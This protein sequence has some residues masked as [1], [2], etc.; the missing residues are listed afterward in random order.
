MT[1]HS[2]SKKAVYA[3]L[4]GNLLIVVTKF[5]AA[6][7]TGSSAM[8][9]EGIHSLVD[10][11]NEVLLLYGIRRASRPADYTHP[12]GH[13]R[14]IYFWSFVVAVLI[15]ALGAGVSLYEGVNHILRPEPIRNVTISYVVLGASALFEAASWLVAL[16]IFRREKG[17]L[18]YFAAI[19]QSKDPTTFTVLFEDSAALLGLLIAALGITAAYVLDAPFFDGLAS[20]GVG[21]V[22]AGTAVLL[23]RESK[24]LLIGERALPDVE[25]SITAAAAGDPD[26]Q[27]VN[28]LVSVHTGPDQVVVG[29]SIEFQDTLTVT[30][31]EAC[32]ERIE[33]QLRHSRPEVTTIF[34]KPQ[35]AE[36]W[37]ARQEMLMRTAPADPDT[38]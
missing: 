10:S 6:W 9:S 15:F 24:G 17:R 27:R 18:G 22:L 11:G 33:A 12:L 19:R 32:V 25:A 36:T 23:A 14:E 35:S 29:L 4:I 30:A 5:I 31:V 37:Q 38:K 26:V 3:A 20:I 8:L 13:G 7:L 16:R 28:G 21:L 2:G 34:I 1:A